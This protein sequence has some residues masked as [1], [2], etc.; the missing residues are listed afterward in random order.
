MALLPSTKICGAAV[1]ASDGTP[2]GTITDFMIDHEAGGIAYAVLAHGGLLGVGEK[3]FAVPWSAFT[4]EPLAGSLHLDITPERLGAG[5]G[6]D[7][8]AW[9][10]TAPRDWL[11]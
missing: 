8:D 10:T 6:I 2:L 5:R 3:L 4:I 1:T 9:P 7:K 11:A